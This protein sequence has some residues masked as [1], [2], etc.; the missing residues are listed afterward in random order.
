MRLTK[1][2]VFVIGCLGFSGGVFA[3]SYTYIH[4][5]WAYCVIAVS[6]FLLLLC[7]RTVFVLLPI[8]LLCASL[9]TMRINSSYEN[10][11][12]ASL[13][14]EKQKFEGV[15]VSDVDKRLDKQLLTVRP[16]GA[17]QNVL[18][19][20]TPYTEY[21]Y[22]DRLLVTGKIT[23]AKSSEDFDYRK[24]LE[25]YNTYGLMYRPKIIV[26]K[27]HE[28]SVAQ[29]ML[30]RF[31][32]YF[33]ERLAQFVPEPKQ[34]LLLG[35]LIGARKTL[36][37]DVLETFRVTGISHI[38]AVSGY[39]ISIIVVALEKLSRFVGRKASL[40]ISVLIIIGFVILSGASSS[41]VRAGVMGCLLLG[42]YSAGRLYSITPALLGAG[43]LMIMVNPRI[44]YWDAGFQ[45]SF[46]ATIGIVYVL[47]LFELFTEK[48]PDI[49]SIKSYVISTLAATV[50]TLPLL[51]LQFGTLSIV[52]PLANVAV[53]PVIPLTMLFGFLTSLPI[54]GGGFGMLVSW[55]LGYILTASS[56]LSQLPHASMQVAISTPVFVVS[57]TA[58]IIVIA[59][60]RYRFRARLN[61][62]LP[63]DTL[64][65]HINT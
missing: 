65:A 35:I 14:L 37:A 20:T 56:K 44:L 51:L 28:A 31:K 11:E 40:I 8:I 58:I 59:L 63:H 1:S 38:I 15:I 47:P 29:E 52:A 61:D 27:N 6:L 57:S 17:K 12:F 7:F 21:F 32:Y 26:L 3:G 60:L 39:N 18:I 48:I 50:A 23:E 16:D 13:L 41:V 49:V 25:R 46:L 42:S 5:F 24:Y 34:S 45:L 10:N 4:N 55:L 64:P 22:G 19:T 30:F 43:S 2:R 33:A 9:G 54:V 53:L 36:P 62:Q